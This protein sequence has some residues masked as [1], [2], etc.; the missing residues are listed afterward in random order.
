[1][2]KNTQLESKKYHIGVRAEIGDKELFLKVSK[3]QRR[4]V[5]SFI[6]ESAL[7]RAKRILKEEEENG[8]RYNPIN[9]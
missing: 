6:L 7:I 4:S 9:E 8:N 1:M 5:A 2:S 3:I